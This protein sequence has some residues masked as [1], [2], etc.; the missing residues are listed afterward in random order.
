MNRKKK[1][2]LAGIIFFIAVCAGI[3][4]FPVLLTQDV[5]DADRAYWTVSF[6]QDLKTGRYYDFDVTLFRMF[7]RKAFTGAA[8]DVGDD[9][10]VALRLKTRGIPLLF[11]KDDDGYH[12]AI[13]CRPEDE[14]AIRRI[15][16]KTANGDCILW[17]DGVTVDRWTDACFK[18]ATDQNTD[19]RSK[20]ET[21]LVMVGADALAREDSREGLPFALT[22]SADL[23][24]L[25]V[26][27]RGEIV[28]FDTEK[29][30]IQE[31]KRDSCY[32]LALF[33]DWEKVNWQYSVDGKENVFSF[34]AAE[35]TRALGK[36]IRS[37][38]KTV[39]GLQELR[40]IF[41]AYPRQELD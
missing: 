17:E 33:G 36:D 18:A 22:V 6:A 1:I 41:A 32:L 14:P 38:G 12:V 13:P 34:S 19:A 15:V 16:L 37:Y 27:Y 20:A 26:D 9:G 3:V 30:L 25:A 35:A 2:I 24:A 29:D 23:H 31:L 39:A 11:P 4:F 21:V 7:D 28:V 8:C 40:E 10:T 5:E